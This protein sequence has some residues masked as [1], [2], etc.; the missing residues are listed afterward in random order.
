MSADAML[1]EAPRALSAPIPRR[2]RISVSEYHAKANASDRKIEYFAGEAMTMP[3]VTEVHDSI[4]VNALGNLMRLLTSRKFRLFTSDM[5]V[6]GGSDYFY[7]DLSLTATAP[8]FTDNRTTLLNPALLVEVTSRSSRKRDR[9]D[10]LESYRRIAS[11]DHYLIIDQHRVFVEHHRR[12][13]NIWTQTTYTDLADIVPLDSLGASLELGAGLP[14]CRLLANLTSASK[15]VAVSRPG[16]PG[17][18]ACYTL[19]VSR[20]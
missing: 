17:L 6:R 18:P 3:P 1:R 19:S 8:E 14:K 11:L 20:R 16:R 5:R 4:T 7:P 10:K 13:G 15:P 2:A 9:A 12:A